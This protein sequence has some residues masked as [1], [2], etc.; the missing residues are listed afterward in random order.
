MK[1]IL[2]ILLLNFIAIFLLGNFA[3]AATIDPGFQI[4]EQPLGM[5]TKDVRIVA[6]QLINTFAG[7]LGILTVLVILYGGF[8]WMVS[9]GDEE[10]VQKAK[11]TLTS[12]IIGLILIFTSYSIAN[13][14]FTT[15]LS[16][17]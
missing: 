3:L 11:S 8:S 10:K 5:G 2:I 1:K 14:I 6:A 12:G 17:T 15:V 7:L 9:F 4:I 13:Y 16:A